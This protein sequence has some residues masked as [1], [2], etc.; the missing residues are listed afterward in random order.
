MDFD[1]FISYSH[2][3][4]GRLAPAV[5]RGLHRLAKPW[6]R[7]RA[8]WI[9][10]DQTGLAVT[11]KL[12]TSIQEALDGS[13]HFVLM[14]S[15]EAARSPWVNREIEH[16]LATKSPDRILPVVTDGD[17]S[18]DP[19]AGDFT[20]ESTAVPAALRGVFAEE[21]LFLD[22]RWARD[23]LH[24][25]LQH[26][27]FR[28]AIAQLA[29]PM[30]GV[31]K[32]EL[33]GEDV[34]Q[35]R[36]ARRLSAVAAAS[37]VLLTLVASLS[38][39]VAVR[40][41]ERANAAAR[42]ARMQQREASQQ[43]S[44]AERATEESQRQQENA[45]VQQDRAQQAKVE[46]RRQ[47]QL[48]GQQQALAEDAAEEARRQQALA[49]DASAEAQREQA[50]AKRYRDEAARQ[51][52][53]A[54]REKANA[55]RQQ[56]RAQDATE[57]AQRQKAN[58][59]RQEANA[60]RQE[61]RANQASARAKEQEQLAE[62]HRELARQADAERRRQEQLARQAGEE[63]R[64]QRE[65]AQRQQRIEINR[66]LMDRARAMIVD[67]PKKAL[68]LAV[69]AQR[70]HTDA[71][72]RDQLAHLVMATHYAGALDGVLD[73]AALA[74]TVVAAAGP[75]GTV[76]LWDTADP[77]KPVRLAVL[78]AD[79]S[80]DKTLATSPDGKMLAVVD[81]RSPAVLWDVTDPAR[82]VRRAS[83]PD[84]AGID[85]VAFSPDGRTVATSNRDKNTVLWDVAG[86]A[87]AELATL[88]G[89][90]PLTFSPDGR[91]AVTSGAA[92]TVWD[93]TDPATPVAG[94]TLAPAYTKKITGAAVA[95]NPKL[96]LVAVEGAGN[97]VWLWN[98]ADPAHPQQGFSELAATG[99]AEL[100]TMA[101]SPDGRTLALA[102][103]DGTTALWSVENGTMAWLSTLVA[104]VS[105]P[106]NP[107]RSLAFSADGR[108]VT[109]AG[110]RS[111]ATLWYTRGRF[112]RPP[113]AS[114]PGP[115]PGQIVGLAFGP[116]SRSLIAAGHN[117]TAV[118][119]DLTGPAGPLR[120]DPL[121]LHGG[122][123]EAITLSR[124]GRTLAVIGTDGTVRLLDLSR[125][126]APALLATV[127]EDGDIVSAVTLSPDGRTLAVGRLDGQF[128]LWDLSDRRQP[129]R[130]AG[131]TLRSMLFAVAFSPDGRTLAVGEGD[132]VSLWDLTDRSA[133]VRLT[134]IP[135]K[136][137][138]SYAARS[139][140][141]SPDGRTLAAGTDDDATA[142][143][144]DVADP[145]RPR[146][147]ATLVGHTSPVLWVAFSPDG[148][149]L[150][151]AS[152][153]SAMMLWDIADPDTPVRFAT[154]KSPDLQTMNAAFSPDGRTLAA[155]G[156]HGPVPG[157][158]TLWDATAP[159]E[160]AAD[161][162]RHAC[163]VAGR[164]L[165]AEE[166]ARYIPELPHQP[167]C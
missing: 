25:S 35:H 16:W 89:A 141:F 98:L 152:L 117:G 27:R 4:D 90:H 9:F 100:S 92:V 10:R 15:P 95:F 155:G 64:R 24:L 157:N 22:L 146:R 116:D 73:V 139:L 81:G 74:G 40:N 5:Q 43:R 133:P 18:W 6:H 150:A 85:A 66:R 166:W 151:T 48:A 114:L 110:G 154:I 144:W 54:K 125:P 34:R 26:V 20:A 132:N 135:L 115:Y 71:P 88:P 165:T 77:A 45:R 36:R 122:T 65:K 44:T 149:T 120:R 82:P 63:A 153:D 143:L 93:L 127:Q 49:A 68:M 109:T 108:T 97:Y 99:L 80:A 148:R 126:A 60:R 167:T 102:D 113:L 39:V 52:A 79:G 156:A 104:T 161:P 32:D 147:I 70:L 160:V 96:P 14:A 3:A 131:L 112:A 19:V 41:A 53:D 158:V 136:D 159:R 1:G 91:T 142:I 37:L 134:S 2:A 76:S 46:T 83:L 56:D 72:T 87:P 7:R 58:A 111:T 75:G 21:P 119:W 129:T 123:A 12:W 130:L 67:D 140:A 137:H 69:A 105:T 13:K 118:P 38:G 162:G 94:A 23:D 33:E 47:E 61:E 163:A 78:P 42:D 29:A 101:F 31:S 50:N 107:V 84:A 51:R 86:A 11:P 103:T 62:Q 57:E 17:W 164:G 55:D 30:H 138:I 28:D 124:D 145:L 59:E 121:P 106:G 128:T 8:L